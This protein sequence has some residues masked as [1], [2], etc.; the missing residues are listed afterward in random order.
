MK[1]RRWDSPILKI[2]YGKKL[3][4]LSCDCV[5]HSLK[6]VVGSCMHVII[7]SL[8]P[9]TQCSRD[10]GTW[11]SSRMGL[12]MQHSKKPLSRTWGQR[13]ERIGEAKNLGPTTEAVV[14]RKGEGQQPQKIT[15]SFCKSSSTWK[16]STNVPPRSFGA[17]RS[18]PGKALQSLE[19]LHALQEAWHAEQ[20]GPASPLKTPRAK[21][22]RKP[23]SSPPSTPPVTHEHAVTARDYDAMP[24]QRL[25]WHDI[26]ALQGRACLTERHIPQTCLANAM[27]GGLLRHMLVDQG[28]TE[29]EPSLADYIFALPKLIWPKPPGKVRWKTRVRN[30]NERMALAQQGKW[31]T[32]LELSMKLPLPTYEPTPEEELLG[33][34]GLSKEMARRLHAAACQGQVGKAWKQMRSPPPS[35]ITAKVWEEAKGKLKLHADDPPPSVDAKSWHP[36][37]EQCTT[38]IYEL[39]HNKAPDMGGWTTES[40]KVVF[41]LPHLPVLWTARLTRL[42][43]LYPETCQARTWHAHKLVCLRKPQG[44]HRPILVS[45]VWIKLISRLLLKEAGAPLKEPVQNVQF[46][47]GVPHG[48]LALLTKVR[49]HLHKNPTRVAAQLDFQNA[50]GTM[51]HKAC[52]E[53]LEKHINPQEPWFLATKNLWSRNVAIPHARKRMS[54]RLLMEY[55][56][57]ILYPHWFL[58]LQCRY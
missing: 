7:C 52:I 30:I 46:G 25:T 35:K 41:L 57:G 19:A 3:A 47:V 15:A 48:G 21:A 58:P 40:A 12:H 42:A 24:A 44:G 37:V 29:T 6:Q 14:T 26:N 38:V 8:L 34:H 49:S 2:T 5:S 23:R 20:P 33:E 11:S 55:P 4:S 54:S 43:H 16:W 50:F 13:G 28:S 56:K 51:H 36:T 17:N 45:S 10:A 53:Q 22:K 32:P 31:K 39:K 27:L 18:T 9:L 1:R